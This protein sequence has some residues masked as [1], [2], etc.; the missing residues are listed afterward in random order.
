MP[1]TPHHKHEKTRQQL[2]AILHHGKGLSGHAFNLLL[3]V[4]IILS[5]ALLPLEF[6]PRLSAY[7]DALLTIEIFTTVIFTFEYILRIYASPK[8]LKYIFSLYG[9]VDLFSIAPF[10]FGFLGTQ[11]L[12]SLQLLRIIRILKLGEIEAAAAEDEDEKM[13]R[14]VGLVAG[15]KIEYVVTRHPLYLIIGCFPPLFATMAGVALLAVFDAQ[16][17]TITASTCLF[18]FALLLLWKVWLDFS[19]DVIFVTNRRLILQTQYLLGRSINQVNY[20]AITNVKPFYSSFLG[21]ILR[22]GNIV[23]ETMAAEPGHIELTTVRHHEKAAHVIMQHS[24]GVSRGTSA[25]T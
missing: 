9:I 10:Y 8:R 3:I 24:F 21:Y 4:L 6:I 19:Y 13:G 20:A 18:L 5:L 14:G 7:H 25:G 1:W 15:E 23:I 12:R 11:Y 2:W 16:P 17:V 22:Y